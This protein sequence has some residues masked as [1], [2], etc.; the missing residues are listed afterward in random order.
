M[1]E[2]IEAFKYNNVGAFKNWHTALEL[3]F[4]FTLSIQ[5]CPNSFFEVPV[6]NNL[7]LTET[8][9]DISLDT[10]PVIAKAEHQQLSNMLKKLV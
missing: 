2:P 3:K 10:R 5:S 1:V 4:A 6:I 8:F 9:I 7:E